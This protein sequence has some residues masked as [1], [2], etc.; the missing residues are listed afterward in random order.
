MKI[1][2]KNINKDLEYFVKEAQKL[3]DLTYEEAAFFYLFYQVCVPLDDIAVDFPGL[4]SIIT[5]LRDKGFFTR[6][7]MDRQV[8]L[9]E[10]PTKY[11][12]KDRLKS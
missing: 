1:T 5:G 11:I 9:M 4:E 10:I 8:A 7:S 2:G 12:G 6:A 3:E